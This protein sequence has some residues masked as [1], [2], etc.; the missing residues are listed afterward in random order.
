[1]PMLAL[2]GFLAGTVGVPV[3]RPALSGK[4]RSRPFPCLDRACGCQ[5]ADQ[6]W[7]SCC[8]FTNRE[9][10]A[11]AK[12]HG[13]TLPD[14]VTHL[15][16]REQPAS[17]AATKCYAAKQSQSCCSGSPSDAGWTVGFVTAIQA[18]KC[19]GQTQMWLALGAAT[20]PPA[21]LSL[22]LQFVDSGEA[23]VASAVLLGVS[24]SPATPPPR[25]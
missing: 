23:S 1:M 22:N 14:F 4:D 17:P 3:P 10:V 6:C 9:K 13:V 25:V 15:A 16:A 11:W 8:C 5:S 2:M 7:R 19:Q 12:K 21:R 20:P 24:F 18:R